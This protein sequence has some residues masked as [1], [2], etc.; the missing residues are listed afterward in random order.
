MKLLIALNYIFVIDR[1]EKIEDYKNYC[2]TK[3]KGATVFFLKRNFHSLKYCFAFSK[4]NYIFLA[5]MFAHFPYKRKNQKVICLGYFTPFKNDYVWNNKQFKALSKSNNKYYFCHITTS[6]LASR[7]LSSDNGLFYNKFFPLGMPRND[8]F[9]KT[10]KDDNLIAVKNAFSKYRK[11]ILYTPTY[12]DYEIDVKLKRRPILGY[13]ED[14]KSIQDLL[15]EFNAVLVVK[16]HP[17][18]NKSVIE[19]LRAKN[20]IAFD[21]VQSNYSL[22]DLM[23]IS[24]L[25]I[26][27]YTSTY[28]D[29]L[30][31]NRPI[32]F[33]FYDKKDYQENRGFAFNNIELCCAGPL[34]EKYEDFYNSLK[35]ILLGKDDYK[36]LRHRMLNLF[37]L[38][39]DGCSSERI[40]GFFFNYI[41]QK[42]G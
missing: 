20:I 1:T 32:I 4:C 31:L 14:I 22:Y 9:Y 26:T 39:T 16:L 30:H 33:N 18:Q 34:V 38:Y 15:E 36:E 10:T 41:K 11:V 7:I 40:C 6:D 37:N 25:L 23:C 27:D 5:H 35:E 3:S 42:N 13:K 28:F 29:Y 12:R 17:L 2:N 19:D 8:L 21:S 24:D